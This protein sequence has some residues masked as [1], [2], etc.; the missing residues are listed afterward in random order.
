VGG[1]NYS[2]LEAAETIASLYGVNVEFTEWPPTAL[3]LES[4]DTVFDSKKLDS[5]IGT[6]NYTSIEKWASGSIALADIH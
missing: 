1:L 2:L 5:I 4:G 3:A 6:T